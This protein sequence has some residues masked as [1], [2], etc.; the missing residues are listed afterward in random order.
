MP[1]PS[2]EIERR[3]QILAAACVVLADRGL[4]AFRVSD[5]AGQA[6]VSGGTVHY[7][8]DSKQDVIAAA[9]EYNFAHS[10]DRRADLLDADRPPLEQLRQV[11]S[12]YL[13]S[14]VESQRAWRVWAELWAEGM[15]DK[16]LQEVNAR[17][18]G[19]W[20]NIVADLIRAAQQEGTARETDATTAADMLVAMVDGLAIQ[21]LL[22]SNEMTLVRAQATAA[23]FIDDFIAR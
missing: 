8:F 20:R 2:V 13:P 7:Y 16:N 4:Q 17:L 14:G 22:G 5:V 6:G 9:F 15:R 23:S 19:Q 1:R 10:L 12:S 3:E 21:V 11:V 18:Y